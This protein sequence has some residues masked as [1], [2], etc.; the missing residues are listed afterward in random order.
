ME[1]WHFKSRSWKGDQVIRLHLN[2]HYSKGSFVQQQ[3]LLFLCI[4]WLLLLPARGTTQNKSASF[5]ELDAACL[6]TQQALLQ[7]A[8]PDVGFSI[9][10]ASLGN[11]CLSVEFP[12]R[13]EGE[14]LQEE[15]ERGKEGMS[16]IG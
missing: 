1:I 12:Q 10:P 6:W 4:S 8:W 16:S 13:T 3:V 11:G 9:Q 2:G 5:E 15:G 14:I 7:G